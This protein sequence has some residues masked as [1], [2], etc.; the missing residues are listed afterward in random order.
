ML[1]EQQREVGGEPLA[2]P[3]VVPVA[4]G[5]G[6]AEPLVGDLVGDQARAGRR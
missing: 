1:G 5:D 3:D 6:V 2:Q 4:L